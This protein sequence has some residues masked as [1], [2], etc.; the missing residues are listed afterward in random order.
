MQ[1]ISVVGTSGSG[2]TTFAARLAGI[3]RVPHIELDALH[4]EA[5]WVEAPAEVFR[6]RVRE[7]VSADR[8][9]VDGNYSKRA[10]DLVWERADTVVWLDYSFPVIFSRVVRRTFRRLVLREECCNGNRE[11]WSLTFS[12]DSIILWALQ[13]YKRHRADYPPLLRLLEQEGVRTITLRS[14]K[15]ADRWLAQLAGLAAGVR[16]F[17]QE[18]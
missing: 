12:R 1:R 2:K 9:V 8:W 15:E 18:I 10:R 3:L 17:A 5:D 13:T 7:A 11:K 14:P 4:W 6:S 16:S